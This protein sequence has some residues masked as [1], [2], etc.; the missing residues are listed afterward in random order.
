LGFFKKLKKRAKRSVTPPRKI[1]RR[2]KRA[3]TPPRKIRRRVK[4]AVTP[5]RKIRRR[6]IRAVTP[7]KKIRKLS[8]KKIIK[9]VGKVTTSAARAS[10]EVA[11]FPLGLTGR[12]Q[13]GV[14]NNLTRLE[15]MTGI[16]GIRLVAGLLVGRPPISTIMQMV[17]TYSKGTKSKQFSVSKS[18]MNL[19]NKFIKANRSFP[20]R[21]TYGR[22]RWY[23]RANNPK[24]AITF[25][26]RVYMKRKRNE[27]SLHDVKLLFHEYVH[28][29][30][31][32][33]YGKMVFALIYTGS[34]LRN[35]ITGPKK[36]YERI[37]FE[38]EAYTWE[39]RFGRWLENQPGF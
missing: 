8:A 32:H 5:P 11:V 19:F 4:R 22:I 15:D 9:S 18:T 26:N 28:T 6:V 1:R 25:E 27:T 2:V 37:N 12:V 38:R 24:G 3:V 16:P 39:N 31:Y 36:A 30:Q 14:L 7:P 21:R 34:Y 23:Y 35:L 10:F 17:E 13:N 29:F 20:Y 33:K